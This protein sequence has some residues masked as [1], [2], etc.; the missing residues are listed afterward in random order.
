MVTIKEL[1]EGKGWT[2]AELA[3]QAGVSFPTISRTEN[4]HPISKASLRHICKALGVDV[5]RIEGV[6]IAQRGRTKADQ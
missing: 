3:T 1:R 2:Q 4:G 6:T 5:A